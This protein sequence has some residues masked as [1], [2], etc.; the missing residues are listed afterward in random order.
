MSK[1]VEIDVIDDRCIYIN[2]YRIA[3]SK[4]YVSENL[5]STNYI[6]TTDRILDQLDFEDIEKYILKKRGLQ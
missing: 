2:D 6:T 5:K 1:R 4:P 3:G